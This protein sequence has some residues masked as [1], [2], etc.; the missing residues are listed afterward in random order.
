M[1]PSCILKTWLISCHWWGTISHIFFLALNKATT[2]SLPRTSRWPTWCRVPNGNGHLYL[3]T[4]IRI[5]K[6]T[7]SL[8]P[9]IL[10]FPA[11]SST[12]FTSTDHCTAENLVFF[13]NHFLLCTLHSP[14]SCP[15]VT[16]SS[17]REPDSNLILTSVGPCVLVKILREYVLGSNKHFCKTIHSL[18]EWNASISPTLYRHQFKMG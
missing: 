7:Y 10:I 2:S 3:T 18:T 4:S 9:Y 6:K 8:F 11:H 15:P 1:F 5:V 16:Q 14:M 17:M 13:S 12:F